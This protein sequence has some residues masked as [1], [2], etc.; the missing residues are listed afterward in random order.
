MTQKQFD[1]LSFNESLNSKWRPLMAYLYMIICAFDFIIAP[2]LWSLLQA[3]FSGTIETPWN[4]LTLQG[5]GLFH[6]A[7]GAI[8]G[9]SAYGRT[10]EKLNGVA[11]PLVALQ[12]QMCQPTPPPIEQDTE[13][14]LKPPTTIKP[15]FATKAITIPKENAV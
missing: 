10:Q 2:I 12:N 9:I 3:H 8:V 14:Q 7:M 1:E 13:Q 5:A 15:S 11:G 6:M 4:P